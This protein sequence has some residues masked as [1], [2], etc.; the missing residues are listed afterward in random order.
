[1]DLRPYS[2][3]DLALTEA[4]ECDPEMMRE[5]GGAVPK[6]D[7]P[8]IHQRRLKAVA[9]GETWW[10]TI[11]PEPGDP[12]VGAIGIWENTQHGSPIHEVGWM[13]L[14]AYQGRGIASRALGLVIDRA[15][16]DGGFRSIHAFPGLTNGPS[17]GLCRKFGF[18]H[19]GEMDGGYA[20]RQ[21]RVNHWR[22]DLEPHD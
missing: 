20:G 9:D 5:L 15:R 17:N 3:A 22:L 11:V 18:V 10:F 16:A 7:I 1:M 2:D 6:D 21:L 13:V 12:P 4:I 14:P 8:A 19:V